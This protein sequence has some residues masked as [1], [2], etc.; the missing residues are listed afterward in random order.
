MPQLEELLGKHSCIVTLNQSE[1][2]KYFC[3]R[4]EKNCPAVKATSYCHMPNTMIIHFKKF[5]YSSETKNVEKVSQEIIYP[6]ETLEFSDTKYNLFGVLCHV[7][8]AS[9]GHYYSY[10][11]R[12]T[13]WF[14]CDD[15]TI[16]KVSEQKTMKFTCCSTRNVP[17]STYDKRS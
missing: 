9:N 13:T 3:E 15:D 1:N 7:G 8:T 14:K 2:D 17:N 12:G 16:S 4:C 10:I 11:K 6:T 5:R